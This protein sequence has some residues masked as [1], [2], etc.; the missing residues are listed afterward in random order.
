MKSPLVAA[1]V[2]GLSSVLLGVAIV[3][4]PV[5][6]AD[7]DD[8]Y[9][10]ELQRRGVDYSTADAVIHVGKLACTELHAGQSVLA[11]INAIK[12][13]GFSGHDTGIIVGSAVNVYCPDELPT[14]QGF[15]DNHQ[16]G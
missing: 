2:A 16:G 11:V 13:G 10:S 6:Q 12:D 9:L 4:A 5:A 15:I 1:L 7:S 8:A 14:L 3:S